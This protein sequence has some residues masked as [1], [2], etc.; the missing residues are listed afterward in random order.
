MSLKTF[1]AKDEDEYKE[2]KKNCV[3]DNVKVGDILCRLISLYNR[4]GVKVFE[5]EKL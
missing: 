3:D 2:F 4:E 1:D 5:T